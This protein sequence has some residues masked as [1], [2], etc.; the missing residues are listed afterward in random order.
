MICFSIALFSIK[1][2]YTMNDM[3]FVYLQLSTTEKLAIFPTGNFA[4]MGV[5]TVVVKKGKVVGF[6]DQWRKSFRDGFNN[7]II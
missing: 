2:Q 6:I 5:S 4:G 7:L 1:L 3:F